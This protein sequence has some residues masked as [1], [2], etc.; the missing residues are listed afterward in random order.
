MKKSVPPEEP[1]RLE[2]F[3]SATKDLSWSDET[4]VDSFNTA[5]NALS[6]LALFEA[7]YYYNKRKAGARWS[8]SLQQLSWTLG[9][10][11]I[12]IPLLPENFLDKL[13]LS[14]DY[15]YAFIACSGSLLAA[16]SLFNTTGNY[17]RFA[18]T[19]IELEGLISRKQVEWLHFM[20]NFNG[21]PDQKDVGFGIIQDY[22][23]SLHLL[24][25]FRNRSMGSSHEDCVRR[26]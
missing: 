3:L 18:S 13:Y 25:F 8:R 23:S 17:I 16:N 19:Q 5:F 7:K 4:S 15:G 6:E 20:S 26:L 1:A 11:G 10:F 14:I 12:L 9:T 24:I 22:A 2:K 21:Q